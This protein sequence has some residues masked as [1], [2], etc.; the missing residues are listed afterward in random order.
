MTWKHELV[1]YNRLV[2]AFEPET[3]F[4][5]G[6]SLPAVVFGSDWGSAT[7]GTSLNLG[8]GMT[9]YASFN[10]QFGQSQV[11]DYGGQIGLNVA[12]G[13]VPPSVVAK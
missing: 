1:P 4:A 3:A 10:S 2:T 7:L 9:A 11:T 13:G 5:P 8:G 12:L 6:Y